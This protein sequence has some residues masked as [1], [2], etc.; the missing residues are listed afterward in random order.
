MQKTVAV[1]F[2][3]RSNEHEISVITGVL[4]ANLLRSAGYSVLPVYLLREGGMVTG[5]MRA[6]S[7]FRTPSKKWTAL[8]FTEG[9]LRAGRRRI[10]PVD[11]ALNCCHGGMGEDGTLSALLRWYGIRS[12]SPDIP[13]SSAFMDKSITKA[14]AKGLGIPVLEG[15]TV[16]EGE[17]YGVPALPLPLIVKPSRLGSS[18]G[19]K[20]ARTEEELKK[21]LSLAFTLDDSALVEPYLA[22]KRDLNCAVCRIGGEIRLSPVEEVF[23]DEDILTFSEKYEGA[24]ERRSELPASVPKEIS[25]RVQAYTKRIYEAF[26]GRGVVRADFLL[27]GEELFFN[28]LNTV[29]GSLSCY[30]FGGTLSGAKNFLVSLVE[31]GL[32]AADEEKETIETGIL[33]GSVFSLKGGKRM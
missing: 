1:F 2:G 4:A 21:A 15:V 26:R 22:G 11:V 13:I 3:G 27:S 32:A 33:R 5:E 30:L 18:I 19:I 6:V 17:D 24:G 14:A 31:E 7:E 16:H 20:V 8:R 10:V 25:D 23:S 29:P 12:A 28:E 9:G